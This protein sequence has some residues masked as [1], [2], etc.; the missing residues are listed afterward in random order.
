MERVE[1]KRVSDTAAGRLLVTVLSLF[2]IGFLTMYYFLDPE[3]TG[4]VFSLF[5]GQVVLAIVG[6]ITYASW[7]WAQ[8]ILAPIE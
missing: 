3:G 8:Y 4:L 6:L 7:R 5:E 2:P 1:N